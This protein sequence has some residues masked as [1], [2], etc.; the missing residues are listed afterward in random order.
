VS[1]RSITVTA[2]KLVL[3][4][5]RGGGRWWVRPPLPKRKSCLRHWDGAVGNSANDSCLAYYFGAF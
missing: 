1:R 5:E 3:F 2:L 4:K